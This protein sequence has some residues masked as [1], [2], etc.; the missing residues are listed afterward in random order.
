L[1]A[2][3]VPDIEKPMLKA[4][5]NNINLQVSKQLDQSVKEKMVAE[6]IRL[7]AEEKVRVKEYTIKWQTHVDKLTRDKDADTAAKLAALQAACDA[8][9]F[10]E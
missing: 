8:R 9:I 7:E 10:E 3:D 6:I 2:P 5:Q 4:M 1:S